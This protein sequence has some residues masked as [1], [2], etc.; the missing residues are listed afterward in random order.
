MF[1]F[2]ELVVAG[3]IGGFIGYIVGYFYSPEKER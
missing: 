2:V 3:F 1:W